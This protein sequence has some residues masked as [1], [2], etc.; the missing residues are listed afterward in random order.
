MP[1]QQTEK[2]RYPSRYS[3]G[4]FVSAAQYIT[5]FICEA[6]ARKEQTSLPIRFWELPDWKKYYQFQVTI[7]NRLLKQFKAAAIL[8]ALKNPKAK[9]IYSLQ[10]PFLKNLIKMEQD[11][12]DKEVK[13]IIKESLNRVVQGERQRQPT[14]LDKLDG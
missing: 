12:L 11:K 1:K 10:A 7:C 2:S 4:K 13:V 14:K 9:Y 8:A 3:P 5:E 6:K